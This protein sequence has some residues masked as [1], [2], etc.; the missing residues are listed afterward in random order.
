M[1]LHDWLAKNGKTASWLAG[2]TG[3]SVSY[4]YRLAREGAPERTPS[5]DTCVKIASATDGAV[6]VVDW[7]PEPKRVRP[8]RREVS[9]AA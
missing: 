6:T 1:K 2:Q 8:S 9:R 7:M 3:L 5:I 4:V